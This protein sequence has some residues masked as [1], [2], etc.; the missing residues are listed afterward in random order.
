MST[1]E[2]GAMRA[3]DKVDNQNSPSAR[4]NS[5]DKTRRFVHATYASF[6]NRRSGGGLSLIHI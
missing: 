3:E 1:K 5:S 2:T 4:L 6:A